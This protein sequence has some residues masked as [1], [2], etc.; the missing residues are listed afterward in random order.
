MVL[1]NF[2]SG[3]TLRALDLFDRSL[4]LF[5]CLPRLS[6]AKD[7]QPR[8]VRVEIDWKLECI[9]FRTM[10]VTEVFA[11]LVLRR[12]ARRKVLAGL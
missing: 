3:I 9:A 5:L 8:K 12:K 10:Q 11:R 1:K 6:P 2:A 4:C 7:Y